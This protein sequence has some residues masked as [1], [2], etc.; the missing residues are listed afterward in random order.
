MSAMARKPKDLPRWRV[1]RIVGNAA[2]EI[3][4][5]PVA[6]A[7]AAIKGAIREHG[8]DDPHE[9]KRLAARPVMQ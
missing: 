8:I 9:Q 1:I 3:C 6:S 5:L 2:R 7:E 4:T